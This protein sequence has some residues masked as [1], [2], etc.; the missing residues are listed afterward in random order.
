MGTRFR[1][2]EDWRNAPAAEPITEGATAAE[3]H[4]AFE[5]RPQFQWAEPD[6]P[7]R[8]PSRI[9]AFLLALAAGGWVGFCCWRADLLLADGLPSFSTVALG[10]AIFCAPLALAGI[11]Y[12][13]LLRTSRGE[14]RRFGQTAEAMRVEATALEEVLAR[15][16]SR[17]EEG[18]RALGDHAH[19]LVRIGDDTTARLGAINGA[20]RGQSDELAR[21]TG[22]LEHA[23][24]GAR[25]DMDALLQDLPRA[26]TQS[27]E[28][29]ALLKEAGLGAHERAG[30]LATALV[31]L[32]QR[33]KDA[34][35]SAG[36]AAQRLAA[37]VARIEVAS[38][39]AGDRLET[40]A[41]QM[42]SSV[43]AA[44]ANAARAVD[45]ARHA[46]E[47]QS[48]A[49]L[50]MIEQGRVA[51]DRTGEESTRAL[52]GR[53]DQLDARLDRMAEQ[54]GR[55]DAAGGALVDKLDSGLGGIEQRLEALGR[56]GA[57][58][59][60]ALDEAI[61]T[62]GARAELIDG[63]LDRG[64]HS[65]DALIAR[66]ETLVGLLRQN[67]TEL[68]EALPQALAELERRIDE[69]RAALGA[70]VPQATKLA[71]SASDAT[72]MLGNAD[73]LLLRQATTIRALGLAAEERLQTIQ[74]HADRVSAAIAG[75]GEQARALVDGAAPQLV[76]ALLR[77]RETA[78]QAA[79]H[80]RE[81]LAAVIPEAARALGNAAH[82][83]LERS[84]DARIEAQMA[85]VTSAGAQAV[86]A[87]NRA[88][89]RLMKQMLTIADTTAAIESRIA[90]ARA[91]NDKTDEDSLSRRVALLIEALNATA[92]N[93]A[94]I[95][96]QD[97]SDSAWTA[98]LRGD[99]G[100]FTRRSVR[101]I[102]S[103][104]VR[105]IQRL[106]G[107]DP[108]FHEQLNR[109]IADF[110]AML[111]R[112]LA[113]RDGST[114]AITL[115]SSDVGKLYVALAQAIERLRS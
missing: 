2:T 91:E 34:E 46:I 44:L 111:R 61:V 88:T 98:Y 22:T 5:S 78:A 11:A 33:S 85:E 6:L 93:V 74:E 108:S 69:S 77:V 51:L 3:T 29:S 23:A 18:R 103:A 50:A 32:G 53:L 64:T 70:L 99:R 105:E 48:A 56:T 110:E 72:A 96:S 1:A 38:D 27:R 89:E 36:G 71:G 49:M 24:R 25:G 75:S 21:Q 9:G 16:S 86:E 35:D 15:L 92:I 28:M 52:A 59:T 112:V 62:L 84:I 81:A 55:N 73:A 4:T 42:S 66:T 47:A 39:V 79:D 97:V 106:Y 115:L 94:G 113:S 31:T 41:G 17:I 114:L 83:A 12:L 45:E 13:L 101:L 30:E 7:A 10:I 43:D 14:A 37:H 68:G 57:A 60:A 80:A 63:A 26:A 102:D 95:L 109:Y 20:L 100:I 8:W 40:A 67:G 104:Q 87:T 19:Q 107:R 76:D 58:R 65:A 90:E 54:L 82:G